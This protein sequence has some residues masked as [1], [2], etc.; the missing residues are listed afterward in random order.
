MATEQRP[1]QYE[2]V[3]RPEAG[4]PARGWPF[5]DRL[6]PVG[7]VAGLALGLAS[8]VIYQ[9]KGYHWTPFDNGNS[10]FQP[11]LLIWLAGVLTLA[12]HF[13]STSRALPRIGTAD[14]FAAGGLML[15]FSPLYLAFLYRWPVQ[16][17]SDE[18]VIMG[19]AQ[20]YASRPSVD[21]FGVSDHLGRP[22]LLFV[23]WGKLGERIGGIDFFHMRLLHALFG[24]I[25]IAI[26][27]AL[28]RQLLPL[29]WAVFAS[30]MLGL[31]HAFLMISRLAMRENT[32]VL[33]EVLAL[34]LLLRGLR[35]DHAFATYCGGFVAGLGFYVYQPSRS[36]FPIWV[37]FLIGLA[38]LYR[39]RFPLRKLL[40]LGSIAAVGFVLMAGPI[41]SAESKI[42]V[43]EVNSQQ[44]T[45]M[46]YHKARELQKAWVFATTEAS[47]FRKNIS[48]G[49][50]TF[51][52]HVVDHGWIYINCG[53]TPDTCLQT[54]GHG[55]VDPLTGILLWIGVAVVG[56]GLFRRRRDEPWPLLM[57]GSF[58]ALWLSFAFLIN[59]S[60]NYTRLLVTLPFVAYLVTE[61]VRN[62]GRLLERGLARWSPA[63]SKRG[64]AALAAGTLAA[65]AFG[66]VIMAWHYV[67]RGRTVGDA[68]GSTGRYIHS[69]P[70]TKFYLAAD[71]GSYKYFDWGNSESNWG[72][73]MSWFGRGDQVQ[74]VVDPST[75]GVFKADPPF[76][77]FMNSQLWSRVG[78]EL[79]RQYPQHDARNVTPDGKLVVF[80][81]P[82]ARG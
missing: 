34:A 52:N 66:N 67:D 36:T 10:D 76:G 49:L 45:L 21:L 44:E 65:V 42:P 32:S 8:L 37:L 30:C 80:E 75:A 59:K 19:I 46:I 54:G 17:G 35:H 20:R 43:G 78:A 61:A 56:I 39:Q 9:T 11:M 63:Y 3:S 6:P 26:S 25:V 7:L 70:D 40:R 47:G 81:V 12:V 57:R 5:L 23:P 53:T 4:T 41:I 55:F 33:M 14:L 73:R 29:R 48:Y 51:N 38:I 79:S 28:F 74:G 16:V 27:Y 69:H 58:L 64:M 15:F 1:I 18:A 31:S 50:T 2:R 22:A 62:L 77:L 71:E 72:G 82:P 68:I 60:P 13:W 24:L